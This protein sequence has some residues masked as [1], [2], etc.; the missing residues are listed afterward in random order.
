VRRGEC[1]AELTG[2]RPDASPVRIRILTPPFGATDAPFKRFVI[3]TLARLGPD[4]CGLATAVNT[5]FGGDYSLEPEADYPSLFADWLAA[6]PDGGLIMCHPGGGPGRSTTAAGRREH[7]FLL[8]ERC[9]SLLA[10]EGIELARS[11]G[12]TDSGARAV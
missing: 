2:R 8:S 9:G 10:D 11:S 1:A 7:D 4:P 12:A 6:A 3:Q 5:G